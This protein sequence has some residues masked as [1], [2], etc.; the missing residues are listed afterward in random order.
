[1]NSLAKDPP[2]EAAIEPKPVSCSHCRLPVPAFRVRPDSQEQFCCSGCQAVYTIIQQNNL[3]Y[4]YELQE[5][6]P[7]GGIPAAIAEG[8]QEYQYLDSFDFQQL[9]LRR[10]EENG[11]KLSSTEFFLEGMHC[12][13]CVWLLEKLPQLLPGVVRVR[14]D[15]SRAIIEVEYLENQRQLSEIAAALTKYGYRPHPY[16]G[17]NHKL[18]RRQAERKLLS[19]LAIAGACFGNVMLMAICLYSGMLGGEDG[20]YRDLFRW[21][22]MILSVPAVFWSAQLFYRRAYGALKIGRIHLDVPISIGLLVAFF[23]SSYHTIIGRGEIYFDSVNVIIFLLLISRFLQFRAHSKASEKAELLFSLLPV[24]AHLCTP[25]GVVDLAIEQLVP[26]QQ[27]EVRPGETVPVDG[28]ILRGETLLDCSVLTGE[29][30]PIQVGAGQVVHA[31]MINSSSPIIIKVQSTGEKTRIGRLAQLASD[32]QRSKPP[33][34][35]LVD[36]LSKWFVLI[37]LT[38]AL[39]GAIL[40]SQHSYAEGFERFLALLLISCPCAL[41]MATPLALS[42]AMGNAARV[43]I[44]LRNTGAIELASK[45]RTLIFDKSGTLTQGK[46]KL[47]KW[48]GDRELAGAILAIEQHSSHVIARSIAKEL[49]TLV[50]QPPRAEQIT[51]KAGR[52]ISGTVNQDLIAIGNL[53]FMTEQKLSLSDEVREQIQAVENEGLTAIIV[54]K[55]GRIEALLG[56]GDQLQEGAQEV[57][58][59]LSGNGYASY[60]FSGDSLAAVNKSAALLQIPAD[61][62]FAELSPEDK[63]KLISEFEEGGRATLMFGDGVNDAAALARASVGIAVH[64]GAEASFLVADG[65]FSRPDLRLVTRF[66]DGAKNSMRTVYLGLGLSAVANVTGCF[67]A[68]SG[69]ITP[70]VA[71]LLMPISSLLVVGLAFSQQSFLRGQK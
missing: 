35:H 34:L 63:L 42:V 33:V 45:I 53:S 15:L 4:Y 10:W 67:L 30:E 27:I 47:R 57:I 55:N 29:S 40:G 12:A 60:I 38:L 36:R 54:A 31:G 14:A 3:G 13:A 52:G 37:V 28:E 17:A 6:I 70:L 22:S 41:G 21:S 59:K 19:A 11:V 64:G 1:M 58:S 20:P 48:W 56:L 18:L 62:A 16:R 44:H 39:V 46:F 65:F 8:K 7:S 43:G 50:E 5:N 32:I 26:D 49:A 68:V 69:S 25:E 9:H 23:G 51:E 2:M 61:H 24:E 71:A 66:L